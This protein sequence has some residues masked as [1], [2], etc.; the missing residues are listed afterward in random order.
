MSASSAVEEAQQVLRGIHLKF[1]LIILA[2]YDQR[3]CSL[4][5]L[6]RQLPVQVSPLF[7]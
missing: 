3:L 4:Q 5:V 7:F 2:F 1:K 6:G